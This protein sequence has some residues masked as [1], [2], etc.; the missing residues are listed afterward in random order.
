MLERVR[1][2][3]PSA[4][5]VDATDRTA[6]DVLRKVLAGAG[7][8][9]DAAGP[10]DWRRFLRTSRALRGVPVVIANAHRAG[11]TR[12][13]VQAD[14]VVDRLVLELAV[15]AGALVL[16]E[17]PRVERRQLRERLALALRSEGSASEAALPHVDMAVLGALALCEPRDVP[18]EVWAEALA[19]L[20]GEPV[21]PVELRRRAERLDALRVA[22]D[23]VSFVEEAFAERLR[24][25]TEARLG[26]G[27]VRRV[28]RHL[29]GWLPTA[30][31]RASNDGDWL[32]EGGPVGRF[33][34]YGLAMHAVQAEMFESLCQDSAALAQLDRTA[35]LDAAACR[36]GSTAVDSVVGDAV[37]LWRS[38]L[39][40]CDRAEWA[41]WLHLMSTVR[42]DQTSAEAVAGCGLRLPWRL[43]WSR[44]RPPGSW[45]VSTLWPGPLAAVTATVSPSG[46][47]RIAAREAWDDRYWLWDAATGELLAGPWR[48]GAPEPGQHEPWWPADLALRRA[49]AWV[50]LTGAEASEPLFN[51]RARVAG[52]EVLC[53]PGGVVAVEPADERA[54]GGVDVGSGQ[55]LLVGFGYTNGGLPDSWEEPRE[56]AL[57]ALFGRSALHRLPADRLPDELREEDA[58]EVL[59]TI[60][61]PSFTSTEMQLV[62]VAEEGLLELT[63]EEV[64]AHVDERPDEAG[65][66]PYYRLGVWSGDTIVL[67]GDTGGVYVAAQE[68]EFGWDE[69]LVASSLRTFLAAVQAYM[70]GRCLLPMASSA[71]ER[72]EIRDSVL[73]DLEWIDEEGSRSEAWATALED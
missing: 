34:V 11:R 5:W 58:G 67:D 21:E 25:E 32:A 19:A 27:A 17:A 12:Q 1:D 63:E 54:F 71:E 23:A 3:F 7:A 44:W 64:W 24:A 20:G 9:E 49:P 16:V 56:D 55:A 72:R 18:F 40:S 42:G 62:N 65:A 59:S 28:H 51:G 22:G 68:G 14:R 41:S 60:G 31:R 10:G 52:L 50:E 66:G 6:E 2:A 61:L 30:A 48:H 38:G 33:A 39:E 36:G 46:G 8:G 43:R 73:S 47:E 70:T 35:L 45:D 69:P 57:V 15:S 37:N 29:A 13:S 4:L 26:A 53:G